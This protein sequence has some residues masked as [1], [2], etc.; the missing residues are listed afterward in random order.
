M[1]FSFFII[2]GVVPEE[3]IEW[4]PDKAPQA[5]VMNK[6]GQIFPDMIGPFPLTYSVIAGIL[7]SG[8]TMITPTAKRIITP[9]FKYDL[10]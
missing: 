8:F 9:N 7:I 3:I 6:K 2:L 4:N 10:L 5:I 1:S